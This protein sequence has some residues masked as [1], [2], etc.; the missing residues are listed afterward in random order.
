MD[1]QDAKRIT[2]G[3]GG[4][5]SPDWLATDQDTL[6]IVDRES[7]MRY[8]KPNSL[9]AFVAEHVWEHLTE[10]EAV[11]A[12]A[13]CYEFLR[14]GGRLSIAVPDG[15]H[16]D[17]TYIEYVRPGGT[18]PGADDHKV[19]YSYQS[20]KAQLE[21]AG[22]IVSLLEYWDEH[23]SFHFSE[24]SSEDGHIRRSKRYDSRNQ[25]GSLTYTSLI[26]GSYSL[27]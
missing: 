20:L 2:I 4:I 6:N 7:F 16:P 23:G 11:Q 10:E 22:F 25:D 17:P 15:F 12:S 24:W 5:S 26:I 14:P 21:E 1:F 13:N 18:G 9:E 3:S 8:W 27:L 19:L